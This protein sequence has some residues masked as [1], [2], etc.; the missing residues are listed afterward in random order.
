MATKGNALN[1]INKIWMVTREYEGL[2]G[3]GGVKDVSR[4]LAEALAK[5]ERLVSV[6]MPLYGFITPA[7]KGFKPLGLSFDVDMPY[8]GTERRERVNIWFKKKQHVAV[9]LADAQRYREK[10]SIYTYVAEDEAEDPTHVQGTGHYDYF[11]MNVL[12]QKAAIALMIRLG[13]K[14]D[15]IHCHDGHTALLPA[16]I[17]EIEGYR[18]YFQKTGAMVT[19][20]NAGIGYHQ[21]V[22]DLPFAQ[23][24]T[25]LPAKLILENKLNGTFDPLLAA[26]SY[27]VMNT[28]SENYARELRETDDD[29]LTGWLGHNLFSRGVRLEGITNGINPLDFDLSKP[30][31]LGLAAGFSPGSGDLAGKAAC[32]EHLVRNL[33]KKQKAGIKRYGSLALQPQNP[34]FSLIG[35]FSEQK[36]VDKLLGALDAL[37]PMDVEFQVIVL[38]SG[39][40]EIENGLIQLAENKKYKGR[41]CVILGYH[42]DLANQIYAAGDFFL[43]PSKYEPCGLTDYIAQLFGNIPIV[44]HVGGLV[45]VIDETTG[46]AYKEHCSAAL[47]GTMQRA[48]K[49]FRENPDKIK[50][51]RQTAVQHIKKNYTWETVVNKYLGLYD[52][53]LALVEETSHEKQ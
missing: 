8:V 12:L 48:L 14:P 37:M 10:R 4:Q 45:K 35:R 23:V 5:T 7:K 42:P 1:N 11:A 13:E 27:A 43:V 32:R 39:T 25:G 44:H 9:Y 17:R 51:I 2:A 40:K 21:E 19:I 31:K 47:M 26:S 53:A 24:M 34:L 15:I 18:H 38:G 28:V 16:M 41:I 6:I 33:G 50:Q 20:H 46:F 22:G 30:K 49:V 3:V 52:D 36:G 29:A